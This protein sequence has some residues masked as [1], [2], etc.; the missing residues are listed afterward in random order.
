MTPAERQALIEEKKLT[1]LKTHTVGGLS[2]VVVA[3]GDARVELSGRDGED[4]LI[5]KAVEQIPEAEAKVQAEADKAAAAKS[6]DAEPVD[7]SGDTGPKPESEGPV[8]TTNDKGT[9]VKPEG[10]E[11]Q[12]APAAGSDA[13]SG[14]ATAPR[15]SGARGGARP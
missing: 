1:A 6:A 3:R 14:S 15:G 11:D 13:A 9:E 4:A 10:T 5:A 2:T 7:E 12:G 8:V